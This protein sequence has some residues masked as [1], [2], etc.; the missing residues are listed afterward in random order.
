[1]LAWTKSKEN[2]ENCVYYFYRGLE[3]WPVQ[4]EMLWKKEAENNPAL[5]QNIFHCCDAWWW[6]AACNMSLHQSKLMSKMKVHYC[7]CP[8][9]GVVL[10]IC[11][12]MCKYQGMELIQS[13]MELIQSGMEFIQSSL[14]H[15]LVWWF[16]HDHSGPAEAIRHW[17]G[18]VVNYSLTHPPQLI[19]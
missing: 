5:D 7:P 10:G 17:T 2:K 1:M 4:M 9:V 13:G 15:K 12:Y 14:V 8:S 6:V 11:T 3:M 16:M 19:V 18:E